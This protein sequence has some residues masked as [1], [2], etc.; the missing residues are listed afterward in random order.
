MENGVILELHL[1]PQDGE[2]GHD[3]IY[4]DEGDGYGDSRLDRFDLTREGNEIRL[5]W[6]KEGEY[7]FPYQE[8]EVHVHGVDV[9]SAYVDEAETVCKDNQIKVKDFNRIKLQIRV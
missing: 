4:S 5:E 9:T 7:P 2:T 6:V 3:L 8:I 1:Y